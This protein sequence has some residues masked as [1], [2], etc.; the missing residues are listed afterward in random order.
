M[1]K[2]QIPPDLVKKLEKEGMLINIEREQK[3]ITV[4]FIY[5]KAFSHMFKKHDT[6]TRFGSHSAGRFLHGFSFCDFWSCLKQC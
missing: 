3:K 6:E 1:D 5:L 4:L 2:L